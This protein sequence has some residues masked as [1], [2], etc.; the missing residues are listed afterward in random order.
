METLSL[1]E[2][3]VLDKLLAGNDPA[4]V[5]L[6][7]QAERVRIRAR[8]TTGVGFFCFFDVPDDA[9]LL[10]HATFHFGDVDASM[11]GLSHG[12]GFVLF[13]KDGRLDRLEGYTYDEVWP[14]TVDDFQLRYQTDPRKPPL[15]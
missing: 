2:Q 7:A 11:S 12:A 9:A 10:G 4:L 13:V 5:T 14:S 8:E 1:F 15:P 3:A 6:R